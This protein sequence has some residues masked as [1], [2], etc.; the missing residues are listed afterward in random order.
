MFVALVVAVVAAVAAVGAA[1]M[2]G[3]CWQNGPFDCTY[4]K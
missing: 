2:M 3:S 1:E 4:S